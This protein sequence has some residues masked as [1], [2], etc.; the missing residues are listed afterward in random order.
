[1]SNPIFSI[2]VPVYCGGQYIDSLID[3]AASQGLAPEEYELIF[4]NDC[5]PDDAATVIQ[6]RI[7]SRITPPPFNTY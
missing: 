6:S 3:T 1:M 2:I 7:D 4:V 5:S